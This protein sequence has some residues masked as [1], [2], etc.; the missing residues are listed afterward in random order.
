MPVEQTSGSKSQNGSNVISLADLSD[1]L[2]AWGYANIKVTRGRDVKVV[3]IKIKS[4]PQDVIDSMQEDAPQPPT[5]DVM[6]DPSNP[7]HAAL[8]IKTRQKGRIQNF[9]DPDYLARLRAHSENVTRRIVGLGVHEDERLY[10]ADGTPAV[11]P[12]ERFT[13]LQRMK[14]SN[15]H[16][17]DIAIAIMQL[18]SFSDEERE[19]FF[20]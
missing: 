1:G 10:N 11:T 5:I 12:D 15:S 19:K 16:F 8:G 20:R 18:T 14:L 2:D 7:E 6:L 13:A 17:S 4:V 9:G 3:Q